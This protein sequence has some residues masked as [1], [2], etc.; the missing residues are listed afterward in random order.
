MSRSEPRIEGGPEVA[1][2]AMQE[3]ARARAALTQD[4]QALAGDSRRLADQL[5]AQLQYRQPADTMPGAESVQ[6]ALRASL[7]RGQQMSWDLLGQDLWNL[8]EL[9]YV[10]ED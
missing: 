2:A 7:P 3:V 6:K 9:F 5:A 4:P 1:M 10:A 8:S